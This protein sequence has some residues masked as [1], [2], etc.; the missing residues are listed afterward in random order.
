MEINLAGVNSTSI[1][2]DLVVTNLVKNYFIAQ[3]AVDAEQ[4]ALANQAALLLAVSGLEQR[5]NAL[6]KL[7]RVSDTVRNE[8]VSLSREMG[9]GSIPRAI[10]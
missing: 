2:D 8:V 6:M 3:G 5:V 7:V 4:A 1:N 10:G 9:D